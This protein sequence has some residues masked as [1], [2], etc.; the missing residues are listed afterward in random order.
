VRPV[1]GGVLFLAAGL[2]LECDAGVAQTSPPITTSAIKL[3]GFVPGAVTTSA[4]KLDG[5]VPGGVTTSAIKLD[6]FVPGPITTSPIKLDGLV[7]R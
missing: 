5:F 7:P 2:A 1:A 6:G 4:I 3:D